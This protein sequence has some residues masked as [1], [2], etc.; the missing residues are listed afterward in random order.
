MTVQL[1]RYLTIAKVILFQFAMALSKKGKFQRQK[2]WDEVPI[3]DQL[4]TTDVNNFTETPI[5]YDAS[6]ASGK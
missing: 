5:S 3:G 2:K 6:E 4:D 1:Y